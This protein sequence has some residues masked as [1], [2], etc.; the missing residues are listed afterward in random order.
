M[1]AV[2]NFASRPR[3]R[4]H[5]EMPPTLDAEALVWTALLYGWKLASSNWSG[6]VDLRW[7]SSY[8]NRLYLPGSLE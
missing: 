1:A 8:L 5:R 2:E 6:V 7:Q 3:Q 4:P